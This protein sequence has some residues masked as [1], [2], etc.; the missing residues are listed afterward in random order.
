MFDSCH[1]LI[2]RLFDLLSSLRQ[3]INNV[4]IISSLQHFSRKRIVD[5]SQTLRR[6][7]RCS[8]NNQIRNLSDLILNLRE[9]L[10]TSFRYS[11]ETRNHTVN[12]IFDE[13]VASW[14]EWVS[15]KSKS[16]LINLS[17]IRRLTTRLTRSSM[18][19]ATKASHLVICCFSLSCFLS[20]HLSSFCVVI[21]LST[22][23]RRFACWARCDRASFKNKTSSNELLWNFKWC[24][25]K[26]DLYDNKSS[27]NRRSSVLCKISSSVFRL[28]V[29][30]AIYVNC[31]LRIWVAH[32][33]MIKRNTLRA[34]SDE[35][36]NSASDDDLIA[37][38]VASMTLRRWH[39]REFLDSLTYKYVKGS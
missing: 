26:R 8:S 11:I 18:S 6:D 24:K 14:K 12:L 39:A 25:T 23:R 13:T 30:R 27:S 34:S 2:H 32:D 37:L 7:V 16:I 19:S 29:S 3:K 33:L 10:Q 4:A 35:C 20:S 9:D 38:V 15:A 17:S 22:I 36:F 5:A 21:E 28:D 1:C 31:D